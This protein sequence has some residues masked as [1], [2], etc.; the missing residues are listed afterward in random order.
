MVCGE[1]QRRRHRHFREALL[2]GKSY[3]SIQVVTWVYV[4]QIH[5]SFQGRNSS[6]SREIVAWL[7]SLI[8]GVRDPKA[9]TPNLISVAEISDL[10]AHINS[11]AIF[12]MPAALSP[13]PPKP[14]LSIPGKFVPASKS[15]APP[16]A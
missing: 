1:Y 12:I 15:L 2:K 10:D 16:L 6:F 5:T 13:R 7:F 11:L 9:H 14:P 4:C 3:L 8:P